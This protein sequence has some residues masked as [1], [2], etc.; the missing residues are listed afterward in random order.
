MRHRV[1]P[2][3]RRNNLFS[4]AKL[5]L[6]RKA[7]LLSVVTGRK[8]FTAVEMANGSLECQGTKDD[9]EGGIK[10]GLKV[11]LEILAEGLRASRGVGGAVLGNNAIKAQ[12]Q[13]ALF[14]DD[15]SRGAIGRV[16]KIDT[17]R[18]SM[19]GSQ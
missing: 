7:E 5:S 8:T 18:A 9:G 1:P 6:Q 13:D 16:K 4:K 17:A 3:V 10:S 12:R 19:G 2:G 11:G 15:M 14:T